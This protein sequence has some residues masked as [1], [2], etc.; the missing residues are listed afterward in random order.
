MRPGQDLDRLRGGAIPGDP[1]VIVPIGAH[2]ISQEFGVGGIGLGSRYVVTVA[3]A[4]SRHRV[5]R[6]H[7]VASRHE[8]L[9]PQPAVG[10]DPDHHLL[11]FFGVAG[12]EL[13]ELADARESLR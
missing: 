2:Q 4:R 1:A 10:F 11:G 8:R 12:Q 5:D 13:M 9:D 3:V 6:I 7:L